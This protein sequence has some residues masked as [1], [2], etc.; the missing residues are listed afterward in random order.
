MRVAKI[1]PNING[2]KSSA[3]LQFHPAAA[4]LPQI[5]PVVRQVST[6]QEPPAAGGCEAADVRHGHLAAPLQ[7]SALAAERVSVRHE[8]RGK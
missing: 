1:K 2:R 3:T 5:D 6:N 8:S 4:S 7:Q